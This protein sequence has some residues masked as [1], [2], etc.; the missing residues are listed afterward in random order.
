MGGGLFTSSSEGREARLLRWCS[1]A[2]GDIFSDVDGRVL[3]EV[4]CGASAHV[5]GGFE[6][7]LRDCRD[8]L[9]L[10]TVALRES[11]LCIL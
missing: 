7:R 1:R 4:D 8:L 5:S 10:A 11:T 6:E 2:C 3:S 9:C